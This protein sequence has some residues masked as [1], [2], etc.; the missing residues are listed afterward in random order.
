MLLEILGTLECL[1]T[2][3]ALVRLQRNVDSDVRGDV[4]ALDSCGAALTPGAGQVEVVSGLAADMS[5]ADVFL[6]HC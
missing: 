3:L 2:E 6:N 4:V 5:L 1:A